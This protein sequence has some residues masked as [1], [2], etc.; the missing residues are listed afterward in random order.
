MKT[1][2]EVRQFIATIALSSAAAAAGGL[3]LKEVSDKVTE[4]A[5]GF[6]EVEVI[7]I[8]SN[9]NQNQEITHVTNLY[10]FKKYAEE[11]P[12]KAKKE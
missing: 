1:I 7:P 12:A 2:T 6:N 5:Q 10:L 8:K 3:S 9:F 11:V 4:Y